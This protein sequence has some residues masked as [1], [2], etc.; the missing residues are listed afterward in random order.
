MVGTGVGL[1]D[2]RQAGLQ[3]VMFFWSIAMNVFIT[4][5]ALTQG[6]F[7]KEAKLCLDVRTNGTMI[8]IKAGT[9]CCPEYFHKPHW[10][11]TLGE[12]IA[13]AESMRKKKIVNLRKQIAKLEK[14]R[15]DTEPC[16]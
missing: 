13:S 12:A 15:F 7:E 10:H 11:E 5:Y 16:A 14:L 1:D 9:G 6:I 2:E 4:K 3:G 8:E